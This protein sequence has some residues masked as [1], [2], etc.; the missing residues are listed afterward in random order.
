MTPMIDSALESIRD[1]EIK[2]FI[3]GSE[4]DGWEP[5]AAWDDSKIGLKHG[6]EFTKIA[7]FGNKKWQEFTAKIGGWFIAGEVQFF[8]N[9]E[10]AISWLNTD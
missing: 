7:I 4:L 1:P 5:R 9:A 2:V 10:D 6:N 8:D 3:D